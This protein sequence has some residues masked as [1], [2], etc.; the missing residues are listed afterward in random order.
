MLTTTHLDNMTTNEEWGGFGYIG[1]REVQK[2]SGEDI[3]QAD[4]MLLDAAIRQGM[5][6]DQLFNWANSKNGRWYGDCWFQRSA[7]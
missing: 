3:A 5:T 7:R 4:A 1:E 2:R 6:E